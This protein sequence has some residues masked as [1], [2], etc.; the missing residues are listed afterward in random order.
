MYRSPLYGAPLRFSKH[1]EIG[2][3]QKSSGPKFL[4]PDKMGD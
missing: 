2:G 3:V 4:D 1:G